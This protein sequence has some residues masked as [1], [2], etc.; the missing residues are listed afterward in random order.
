MKKTAESF[1][2]P[3]GKAER[4]SGRFSEVSKTGIRNSI[5]ENRKRL[6]RNGYASAAALMIFALVIQ[7]VLSACLFIRLQA[8]LGNCFR[9]S[10]F[11]LALYDH[12]R[13][14]AEQA[15]YSSRCSLQYEKPENK[16]INIQGRSVQFRAEDSCISAS[17]EKNGNRITVRLFYDDNG[18]LNSKISS[19]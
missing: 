6:C 1:L 14:M 8:D 7:F 9:Q 10:E 2:R 19:S 3:S 5:T 15:S 16:T 13:H 11:D 4:G 12:C 17:Y 18:I